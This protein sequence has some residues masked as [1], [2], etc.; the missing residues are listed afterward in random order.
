MNHLASREKDQSLKASARRA[1]LNQDSLA[2]ERNRQRTEGK[3]YLQRSTQ[4]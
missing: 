2:D 1:P 4:A 3:I